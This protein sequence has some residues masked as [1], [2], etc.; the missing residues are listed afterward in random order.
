MS[1]T[2]QVYI[3][4]QAYWKWLASL[5]YMV[6][7]GWKSQ[8]SQLVLL[9]HTVFQILMVLSFLVILVECLWDCIQ[10]TKSLQYFW[11]WVLTHGLFATHGLFTWFWTPHSLHYNLWELETTQPSTILIGKHVRDC[12]QLTKRLQ[13]FKYS[14]I[15]CLMSTFSFDSSQLQL[16]NI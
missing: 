9:D 3:C 13:C 12:T 8:F 15:C 1:G 11:W 10:L 4:S 5:L 14:V 7:V 6:S 16:L 2:H